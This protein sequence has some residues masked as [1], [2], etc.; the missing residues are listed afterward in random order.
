MR[1]VQYKVIGSCWV[2]LDIPF[3]RT[4][5]ED[6]PLVSKRHPWLDRP[7]ASTTTSSD[8]EAAARLPSADLA[9]SV[10]F[11]G[12][13]RLNLPT[14]TPSRSTWKDDL[15]NVFK[16]ISECMD[17]MLGAVSDNQSQTSDQP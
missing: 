3:H 9:S 2:L 15:V 16:F 1:K 11:A 12:P 7:T 5:G 13:L 8:A 17:M 6:S 4:F 10:R 14:A